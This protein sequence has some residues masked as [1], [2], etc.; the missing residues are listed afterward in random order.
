MDDREL[1]KELQN[2]AVEGIMAWNNQPF[3]ISI[4]DSMI[5]PADIEVSWNWNQNYSQAGHLNYRAT[6][7]G[8]GLRYIVEELAITLHPMAGYSLETLE[9]MPRT[10]GHDGVTMVVDL[11]GPNS[12][13]IRA[14][15]M[16]EMGH[17]LG[18][19]HSDREGDI[20]FPR[21]GKDP[22]KLWISPRD[23]ATVAALYKLPNGAKVE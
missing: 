21:M 12:H 1:A 6:S 18:L 15:A 5:I 2:A 19:K 4:T 20:M 17:A 22:S 3:P 16:H 8:K 13:A 23:L 9:S 7:S 10:L 14:I 11:K